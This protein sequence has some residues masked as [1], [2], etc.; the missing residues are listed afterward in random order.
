MICSSASSPFCLKITK[1]TWIM[2]LCSR[3]PPQFTKYSCRGTHYTT[4][5]FFLPCRNVVRILTWRTNSWKSIS[6]LLTELNIILSGTVEMLSRHFKHFYYIYC[7]M[8]LLLGTAAFHLNL[9]KFVILYGTSIASRRDIF[10]TCQTCDVLLKNNYFIT[11][12]RRKI[13]QHRYNQSAFL[14]C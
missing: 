12:M 11:Y 8:S 3:R 7:A 1:Q 2:I 13:D 10:V 6:K 14:F 9:V 5:H 4:L